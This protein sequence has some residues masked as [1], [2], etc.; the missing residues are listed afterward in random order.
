ME[1]TR[2]AFRRGVTLLALLV[3]VCGLATGC[4]SGGA[5]RAALANGLH[6]ASSSMSGYVDDLTRVSQTAAIEIPPILDDALRQADDAIRNGAR[7]TE[8]EKALLA[9]GEQ[10]AAFVKGFNEVLS[11]ATG[12]EVSIPEDA[13]RIANAGFIARPSDEFRGVVQR[14]EQKVLKGLMCQVARDG[15]DEAG[16]DQA[17]AASADYDAVGYSAEEVERYIWNGLAEWDGVATVL[18][19]ASL[20]SESID[21]ANEHIDGIVDI[22]ESPDGAVAAA[23]IIYFRTCVMKTK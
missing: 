1:A 23:N 19:P 5:L 6:E 13:V 4:G 21:Q 11:A 10:W 14:L 16:E 20:A 17:A 3:T 7:L 15:L 9:K 8:E 2:P 18:D 22:I 12:W